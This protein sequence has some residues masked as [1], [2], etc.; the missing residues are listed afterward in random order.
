MV[1]SKKWPFRAA[2]GMILTVALVLVPGCGKEKQDISETAGESVKAEGDAVLYLDGSAVSAGEYEMLARENSSQVTMQYT[3]DQVNQAD[4]WETEIDGEAPYTRLAE[5]VEGQLKENYALKDLAVEMDLTEDYTYEDLMDAMEQE[6]EERAD[7]SSDEINYGLSSYDESSYYGY[8]YSN[9]E[10]KVTEALIQQD[11]K[12][13]EKDCEKYYEENPEAFLC[14]VG[15]TVLYAEIPEDDADAWNTARQ[16]CAA[17]E[18]GA[19]EEEINAALDVSPETLELS[20]LDTQ[21]GMSGIYQN[22][23]E[24]ASGLSAGQ[25]YGPYEDQG[26]VCVMK[27]QERRENEPVSFDEVKSQIER[28]LQVQGAQEI[29]KNRTE[30]MKVESGTVTPKEVIVSLMQGE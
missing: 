4:F 10:T 15:V 11:V 16:L 14:E 23:W 8:W 17:L 7:T 2:V 29:I 28:Y 12:I 3:T 27:C 21:A 25:V 6:N 13:S 24:I 5:L 30:E 18:K 20:S 1:R 9:L 22:R 26:A 19:S